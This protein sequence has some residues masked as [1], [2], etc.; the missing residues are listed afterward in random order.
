ML[1]YRAGLSLAIC[2]VLSGCLT[3]EP[4]PDAIDGD[5]PAPGRGLHLGDAPPPAPFLEDAA[6]LA[7]LRRT[8][9]AAGAAME[10][11]CP[12][13]SANSV[14]GMLDEGRPLDALLGLEDGCTGSPAT[15][16]HFFAYDSHAAGTAEENYTR[17]RA[18]SDANHA[19]ARAAIASVEADTMLEAEFEYFLA[20]QD[21]HVRSNRNNAERSM[22]AYRADPSGPPLANAFLQVSVAANVDN[23]TVSLIQAHD[24]DAHSGCPPQAG[25]VSRLAHGR[26][27]QA[28]A[29][30]A[31]QAPATEAEWVTKMYGH[32]VKVTGDIMEAGE[33]DAAI[34]AGVATDVSWDLGYWQNYTASTLPTREEAEYLIAVYRS[35]TRTLLTEFRL[36]DIVDFMED[37]MREWADMR[38]TAIRILA[39]PSFV[40]EFE[41]FLCP[42]EA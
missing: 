38:T 9:E 31:A 39:L 28:R 10:H 36:G 3:A 7:A 13:I 32:L 16:T 42:P 19:R 11:E 20:V 8:I 41:K 33:G 27:D 23:L 6:E 4:T 30:A 17:M 14:A 2:G 40:S 35:H 1:P 12:T 24:W 25:D 29:L 21:Q 22:A 18:K 34:Q 26:F 15:F 5:L 37:P